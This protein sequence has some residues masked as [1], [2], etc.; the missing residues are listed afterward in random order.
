MNLYKLL[1]TPLVNTPRQQESIDFTEQVPKEPPVLYT[2]DPKLGETTN[3]VPIE[4]Q[5]RMRRNRTSGIW[6]PRLS[7]SKS[8]T[9]TIKS[10]VSLKQIHPENYPKQLENNNTIQNQHFE[11]SSNDIIHP[12][13]I[14][15]HTLLNEHDVDTHEFYCMNVSENLLPFIKKYNKI[16]DNLEM[17]SNYIDIKSNSSS[18]KSISCP[19]FL[20]HKWNPPKTHGLQNCDKII[21]DYYFQVHRTLKSGPILDIDYLWIIKDD[22]RNMRKLNDHQIQYIETLDEYEK[23]EIIKEFNNSRNMMIEVLNMKSFYQSR[24]TSAKVLLEMEATKLE[25]P[26]NTPIRNIRANMPRTS[27]L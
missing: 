23:N 16:A 10:A 11:S 20:K 12:C 15:E 24:N 14:L 6:L 13:Y 17:T 8:S 21:P 1:I 9:S 25:S 7:W 2:H 3:I 22:I 19:D 4:P 5:S 18:F 27:T 26:Q